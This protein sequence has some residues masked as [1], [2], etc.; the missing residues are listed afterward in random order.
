[1]SATVSTTTVES[2]ATAHCA[3]TEAT[4]DCYVRRASA[5]SANCAA[6]C[7]TRTATGKSATVEAAPETAIAGTPVEATAEP[8]ASTYEDAAREPARTVVAVRRAGVWV[9]SIVAVGAN[10][11]RADI[12]WT[13]AYAHCDALGASVRCQGE[14]SSKYR[15]NHEIFDKMFHVWAPSE[16]V[17]PF[18]L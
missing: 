10:G 9:I 1:M 12:T 8:G 14:C 5:E 6:S 13:D 7:E 4:A 11:G 15:K 2:A 3:A 17:K 18:N 16:P